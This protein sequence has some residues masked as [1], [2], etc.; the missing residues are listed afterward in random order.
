MLS[1]ECIHIHLM[2][3]SCRAVSSFEMGNVG[4]FLL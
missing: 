2:K 3:L 1:V 4:S